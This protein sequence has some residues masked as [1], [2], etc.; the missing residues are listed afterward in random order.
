MMRAW[1]P[2]RVDEMTLFIMI[3]GLSALTVR[4]LCPCVS[5]SLLASGC[6]DPV[7]DADYVK[8]AALAE[9][10]GQNPDGVIILV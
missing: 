7:I 10:R 9:T 3:R 1:F 6:S 2:L 4:R 8:M 5:T